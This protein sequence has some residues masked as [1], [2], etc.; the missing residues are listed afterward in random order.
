MTENLGQLDLLEK[1]LRAEGID[2][3]P[4]GPVIQTGQRIQKDLLDHVHK[5]ARPLTHPDL[6]ELAGELRQWESRWQTTL[7]TLMS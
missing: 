6:L 7:S 1:E 5:T 4:L 3:Q 2:T